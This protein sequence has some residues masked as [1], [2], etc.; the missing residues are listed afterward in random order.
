MFLLLNKENVVIDVVEKVK[1][2]TKAKNGTIILC[3]AEKAEG[4][5]GSDN[6]TIYAKM[7]Y[8]FPAYTDVASVVE[9]DGEVEPIVCKYINGEV[10][11][12]EDDIQF[13]NKSLTRGFA[14]NT[15]D[16][17]YVA[18]MTGVDI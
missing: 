15:A 13:S 4:Y 10:V 18:M 17:E 8:G 3:E 9:Y 5:I 2:V 12:N 6:D 7:G 11:E 14:K 16:L 1:T